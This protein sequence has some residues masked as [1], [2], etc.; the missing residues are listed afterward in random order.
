MER[1]DLW[2]L[3]EYSERREAFRAEVMEYKKSRRVLLG[4]HIMLMFED[5][6]TIRYQIQEMLRIEKVFEVAG[7]QE[8][9]DAYNPLIPDGDN[10]K[11]SMLIQYEDAKERK[12][13]LAELVGVEDKIW[14]Q[15]GDLSKL[16]PI[17]DE[18]MDR[19]RDEKTSAV[20]FLR[21]QLSP[22]HIS[23]VKTGSPLAAGVDHPA[24]PCA[25]VTVD[26]AT[27]VS[28]ASDLQAT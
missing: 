21:Y 1:S 14:F 27:R 28:L 12:Q 15:V 10:W 19:S 25:N 20:H 9:L 4:Q 24:F 18:D 23:A 8:E 3:E 22:A 13:R 7:I 2:S 17:A 26:D 5:E 11:C 6:M 16:Y